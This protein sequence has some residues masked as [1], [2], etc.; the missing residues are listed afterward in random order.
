M[1]V[2]ARLLEYISSRV[3]PYF[4]SSSAETV[5][6][7]L[8]SAIEERRRRNKSQRFWRIVKARSSQIYG[9]AEESR[10]AGGVRNARKGGFERK[11]KKKMERGAYARMEIEG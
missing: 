9:E 5:E 1:T 4:A 10:E 3:N 7:L 6:R 8:A 2:P 11:K